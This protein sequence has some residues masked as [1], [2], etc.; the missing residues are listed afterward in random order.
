MT[1]FCRPYPADPI[2]QSQI[3][4]L[5][6]FAKIIDPTWTPPSPFQVTGSLDPSVGDPARL[7]ASLPTCRRSIDKLVAAVP[8]VALLLLHTAVVSKGQDYALWGWAHLRDLIQKHPEMAGP[9]QPVLDEL[10]QALEAVLQARNK[11]VNLGVNLRPATAE[12]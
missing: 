11:L 6:E 10:K 7:I 9:V 5:M 1:I 12:T 2:D 3:L 4:R 8:P